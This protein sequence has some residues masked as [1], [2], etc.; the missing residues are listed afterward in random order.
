MRND[1]TLDKVYIREITYSEYARLIKRVFSWQ[2]KYGW[3]P[4]LILSIIIG[5]LS[6][7]LNVFK[8]IGVIL[9]AFWS[10]NMFVFILNLLSYKWSLKRMKQKNRLT[11]RIEGL[12]KR[13]NRKPGNEKEVTLYEP[14]LLTFSS[15]YT[16]P[17]FK[18][19]VLLCVIFFPIFV[20]LAIVLPRE[21]NSLIFSINNVSGGF[22]FAPFLMYLYINLFLSLSWITTLFSKSYFSDCQI[23]GWVEIRWGTRSDYEKYIRDQLK[24]K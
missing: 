4:Y 2:M 14:T 7:G 13:V 15:L 17:I 18:V 1:N 16:G 6:T 11:Y 5:V 12:I 20:L 24:N 21:Y 23:N 22:I 9:I 3:I 19:L 8:T 10:T